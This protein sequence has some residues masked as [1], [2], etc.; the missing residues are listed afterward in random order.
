[1]TRGRNR[2]TMLNKAVKWTEFFCPSYRIQELLT[3]LVK[4]QK[5]L[6]STMKKAYRIL[7]EHCDNEACDLCQTL[8][9]AFANGVILQQKRRDMK[10]RFERCKR[11]GKAAKKVENFVSFYYRGRGS[12]F[13][14]GNLQM[15][16][17]PMSSR[18]CSIFAAA[19]WNSSNN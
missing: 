19:I 16:L 18:A 9:L 7:A 15:D 10:Q 1:M 6:V 12:N 5:D 8:K 13:T 14:Y 4:P 11:Y 3:L 17:V 2:H